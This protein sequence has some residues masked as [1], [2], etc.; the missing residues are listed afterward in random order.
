MSFLLA[1]K[2]RYFQLDINHYV[3]SENYKE[4]YISN[5]K[6]LIRVICRTNQ[7]SGLTESD[8]YNWLDNFKDTFG[9]FIA[10]KLLIHSIYYSENNVFSLLEH[11]I[12]QLIHSQKIKIGL[13][14]KD[15][16]LIS[17]TETNS[18]L[19]ELVNSTALIPLLD[20]SKPGES[21]NQMMRYLI[22]KI[23]INP[24]QTYFVDNLN[25]ETIKKYQSIIF[26]DDCIGSGDQLST[27]FNK[28]NVKNKIEVAHSYN[29][30]I[31]YLILTGYK[32]NIESIK[33]V[34]NLKDINIIACDE[35]NEIDKVF[36]PKNIIWYNNDEYEEA[37]EYFKKLEKEFGISQFG[38]SN[39]DF[40]VFIHNTIPDW[41]L[42]IYWM[43]NADWTPLMK[44]KN[45]NLF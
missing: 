8:I 18:L 37:N 36:N 5:R 45:S 12:K 13:V 33:L 23:N 4:N 6:S 7:W 16:I 11:G 2:Y 39:L 43:E 40:S 38:Y 35:L 26:I 20:N 42:P 28:D 25:E 14:E 34:P 17:R 22:Q 1:K 27:F 30:P 15:N 44:R 29:I 31:Y 41:S 9:K 24:S 10:I 19:K 3:M 21:A 32:K